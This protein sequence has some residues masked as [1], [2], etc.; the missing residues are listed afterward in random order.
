[1][2]VT[3]DRLSAASALLHRAKAR[4]AVRIAASIAAALREK[5]ADMKSASACKRHAVACSYSE[6]SDA[7]L[8]K[9]EAEAIRLCHCKSPTSTYLPAPS[10]G[11]S[12]AQ[13][14]I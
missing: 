5:I 14:V 2:D 13:I 11:M 6:R 1:M 4:L 8:A 12:A 3:S 9:T 10:I 7:L